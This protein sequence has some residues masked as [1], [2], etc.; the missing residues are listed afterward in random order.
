MFIKN[1]PESLSTPSRVSGRRR[2]IVR[3]GT[4]PFPPPY[5]P[6]YSG[7]NHKLCLKAEFS[8]FEKRLGLKSIRVKMH[9]LFFL[10]GKRLTVSCSNVA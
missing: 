5:L 3:T 1:A 7:N 8:G 10:Q 6:S 9:F 2:I 4:I